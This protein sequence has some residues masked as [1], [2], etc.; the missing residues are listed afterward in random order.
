M[1][2]V[3]LTQFSH[4]AGC[5]CKIAPAI[6][7]SILQSEIAPSVFKELL[8][9]NSSKDDAAVYDLGNGTALIST[10]DFFVPIVD[11]PYQFG[12]IAA[13]NAISD[14]YA[15][16]GKPIMALAILGW[17]IDKLS[18]EIARRVVEGGRSI[19]EEAGIPLAGG[20]SVDTTEPIF[21]LSVN[22]IVPINH[23]KK[24][25]TA[26]IGDLL[27]LTK[28][29]GVGILS[30]AQKK[31]QLEESDLPILIN[32][33]NQLNKIGQLLGALEGVHAMTDVTGFGLIGHL[34]EMVEGSNTGALINYSKVPVINAAKKYLAKRLV[35]DATYRNWNAYSKQVG[36]EKGVD[37]ME[38]FSI[39]PDPQTNGGLLI[40]V[41]CSAVEEIKNILTQNGLGNHIEEIGK[42][43]EVHEKRILV[44]P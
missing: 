41:D 21:G 10:T 26:Q 33:L 3:Q 40:S 37:V 17:P 16:G 24:N 31:G 42:V 30:T 34:M 23:L 6:L 19:C 1:S 43:T 27:F 22:G 29:L 28:P 39:L 11:D 32:Q 20:H 44:A 14:V 13:A 7:D 15:M 8:V 9:G 2:E 18:P 5:G 4:G 12:R 36:F 25:S 35:P 38:A